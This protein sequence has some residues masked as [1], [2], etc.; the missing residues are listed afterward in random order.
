MFSRM[1]ECRQDIFEFQFV[2]RPV[3]LCALDRP[4]MRLICCQGLALFFL[5][6]L[7]Q[8]VYFLNIPGCGLTRI[9]LLLTWP[10]RPPSARIRASCISGTCIHTSSHTRAQAR[11]LGFHAGVRP[12]LDL[13]YCKC[14]YW[15]KKRHDGATNCPLP[16]CSQDLICVLDSDSI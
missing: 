14:N 3:F 12:L 15:D 2:A 10:A 1:P 8:F 4:S 7:P 5:N 11:A 13:G 16:V 9:S 6:F